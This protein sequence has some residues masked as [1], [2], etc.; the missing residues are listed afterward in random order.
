M[1][2]NNNNGGSSLLILLLCIFAGP[3]V[4]LYFILQ[5]LLGSSN[6]R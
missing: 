5:A 1:S 2:Q 6:K 4:I 3:F